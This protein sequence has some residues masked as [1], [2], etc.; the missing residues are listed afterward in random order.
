MIY[1]WFV[2]FVLT[3]IWAWLWLD[4]HRTKVE[5]EAERVAKTAWDNAPA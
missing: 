2:A 5:I 1:L 4:E 3:G